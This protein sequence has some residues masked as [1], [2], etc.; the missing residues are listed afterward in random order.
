MVT[1][2]KEEIRSL[3]EAQDTLTTCNLGFYLLTSVSLELRAR[4]KGHTC[5]GQWK[6]TDNDRLAFIHESRNIIWI[7]PFSNLFKYRRDV[8][9]SFFLCQFLPFY[10][11]LNPSRFFVC[12]CVSVCMWSAA[13][14]NIHMSC[15]L[16]SDF[17]TLL[18]SMD[19]NTQL[20]SWK[21]HIPHSLRLIA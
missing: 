11:P 6:M 5:R 8:F 19:W 7:P 12:V 18:A 1:K 10:L 3:W 15:Y 2:I 13:N 4:W 20:W 21:L 16:R 9:F 17:F 14:S